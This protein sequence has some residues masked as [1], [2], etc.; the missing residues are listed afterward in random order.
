MSVQERNEEEKGRGE[1]GRYVGGRGRGERREKRQKD[2]AAVLLCVCVCP[3]FMVQ[4][5]QI[6]HIIST[7]SHLYCHWWSHCYL[8]NYRAVYPDNI[9]LFL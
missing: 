3:R 9:A 8:R 6:T 4:L 1:K 5:F 7:R 2:E